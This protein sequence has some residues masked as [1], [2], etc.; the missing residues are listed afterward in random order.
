MCAVLRPLLIAFAFLTAVSTS[1]LAADT[2]TISGAAFD[3]TG[4][5]VAD[6]TVKISGDLLPIGRTVQT[7]DNGLFQFQYLTPG[8]YL[9]EIDKVGVGRAK[10]AAVVEVGKDTQVDFV[11]GLTIQEEVTVSAAQPVVDIRSAEV[12]F[13]FREDVLNSLPART[14]LPRSLSVDSGRRRQSQLCRTGCGRHE[15]REPV[16]HRWRQHH[17]PCVRLPV[18]GDQRARHR[19]GQHQ[20]RGHQRRVR[21]HERQRRQRR[22]PQRDEPVFPASGV[23]TGSRT[24]WSGA[25]SCP[26]IW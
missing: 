25:T 17:Q 7:G 4:A 6:A 26:P 14:N 2:G 15:T 11:L 22:Q 21:P 3:Q 9:V 13:N 5:P 8:E 19:G 12:G 23:S 16:S 1:A 24:S 10:R 20:A 18:D